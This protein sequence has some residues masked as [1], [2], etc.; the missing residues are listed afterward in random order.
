MVF[1]RDGPL[2]IPV[3]SA[4]YYVRMNLVTRVTPLLIRLYSFS[5]IYMRC[6][7]GFLYFFTVFK[8]A[9]SLTPISFFCSKEREND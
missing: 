3:S 5:V 4:N 9:A 6:F 2:V 1:D 7:F 8:A